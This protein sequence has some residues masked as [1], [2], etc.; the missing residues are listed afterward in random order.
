MLLFGPSMEITA[1]GHQWLP[2]VAWTVEAFV[3]T[4]MATRGIVCEWTAEVITN[5]RA[6]VSARINTYIRRDPPRSVVYFHS[7]PSPGPCSAPP[8]LA[9]PVT[10]HLHP[11]LSV[12]DG[13]T[14]KCLPPLLI[15]RCN[16]ESKLRMWRRPLEQ[17]QNLQIQVRKERKESRGLIQS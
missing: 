10:A 9:S 7:T 6:N 17:V 15:A 4:A 5:T 1:S 3:K 2:W 14:T 11:R 12:C 16:Q 13:L 8:A